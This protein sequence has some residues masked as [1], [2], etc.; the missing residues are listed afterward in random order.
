M[1]IGLVWNSKGPGGFRERVDHF[2]LCEYGDSMIAHVA[3][4][5]KKG[6]VESTIK[7]EE[8]LG[9]DLNRHFAS[10]K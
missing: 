3:L 2:D 5:A 1:S 4:L 9:M 10:M 6:N 8:V 7:L